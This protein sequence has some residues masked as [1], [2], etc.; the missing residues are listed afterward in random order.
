MTA[1]AGAYAI[2][3]DDMPSVFL[4]EN[5]EVLARVL[6]LELVARMPADRVASRAR[7]DDMRSALLEERWA[8]ALISWIEETDTPVDVYEERLSIWTESALD[9]E[10]ASLE[11]R[12]AP[13][14]REEPE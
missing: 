2:V 5:G 4:A 12:M 8:D 6:A 3:R 7:L 1:E 9:K 11:I 14:F 10:A 13:L